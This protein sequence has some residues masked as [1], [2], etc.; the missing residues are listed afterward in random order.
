[1]CTLVLLRRPHHPWPLVLAANR[2]ELRTRRS[3]PPGPHWPDRP[4][5]VA[6]LDL[7]AGGSWLG[8]NAAGVLAAVLN[9]RG[10][11]G[12]A[13]GKRSRGELILE[14][15]DHATAEDAARALN[16]LDPRAWRPFNLVVA[17][18]EQAFWLRHA[19]DGVLRCR[20]LPE[21]L[22]MLTAAELDDP[23]CAR[24]AYY[25]PQFASSLPDPDRG[26]FAAW[27]ALLAD[28]GPAQG[29]PRQAMCLHTDGDYGTVSSS[30]I[31]FPAAPSRL[32]IWLF[33]DG[34]PD[35]A[36]F[37]SVPPQLLRGWTQASP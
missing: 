1:M 9:R 25:R 33:A 15:L 32:P 27:Q 34:P 10:S 7:E 8:L 12:P 17:D 26:D 18:I 11:L 16:D 37:R 3:L 13:A 19:G 28:L 21:G 20:P 14:A 24:I 6:G 30:L 36:P 29:D 2:D 5:V 35:R 4:G 23:S 22:S 31:A